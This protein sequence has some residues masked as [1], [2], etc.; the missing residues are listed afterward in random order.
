MN[1]ELIERLR[2]PNGPYGYQ[3][4]L[5]CQAADEIERLRAELD[6]VKNEAEAFSK[7]LRGKHAITGATYA[8]VIEERDNLRAE[9]AALKAAQSKCT[10]CED[11]IL[12]DTEDN[13]WPCPC[14]REKAAQSEPVGCTSCDGGGKVMLGESW[15]SCPFCTMPA[16]TRSVEKYNLEDAAQIFLRGEEASKQPADAETLR[17]AERYR[18]LRD[19]GTGPCQIWETVCEPD[20]SPLYC[21]LKHSEQLD[22]AIDAAMKGDQPK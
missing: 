2:D 9:L 17:D 5:A 19:K 12:T 18:W 21:T 14:T 10:H 4:Q 8:T 16:K 13:K 1:D 11:G 22:A 7:N 6:A 20:G 3:S 15:A